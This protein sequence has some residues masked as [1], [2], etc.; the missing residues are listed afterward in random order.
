MVLS[1]MLGNRMVDVLN[2][3]L[4]A[5]PDALQSLV[6]HRV[7]CNAELADHRSI[8]VMEDADG[9]RVGL[10]GVLNGVLGALPDG[11]GR[12]LAHAENGRL[13]RFELR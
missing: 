10:L 13:V 8:Q 2:E 12:L 7:P 1:T 3:A 9:T 5:D 4:A 11:Q 6:F